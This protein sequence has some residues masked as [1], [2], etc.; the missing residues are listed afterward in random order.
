M[1]KDGQNTPTSIALD[2]NGNIFLTG[3]YAE[4]DQSDTNF[5]PQ[6]PPAGLGCSITPDIHPYIWTGIFVTRFDSNGCYAWTKTPNIGEGLGDSVA[7]DHTGNI[8]IGGVT[9][10]QIDFD[11]DGPGDPQGVAGTSNSFLTKLG[12]DG[13]YQWTETQQSVGFGHIQVDALN[14]VYYA[15]NFSAATDFDPG[16]GPLDVDV[17]SPVG[18]QGFYFTKINADGTYGGTSVV[19]PGIA[20]TDS[21][22]YNDVVRDQFGH[23]YATGYL[24]DPGQ[25]GTYTDF[26][27][28]RHQLFNPAN[29]PPTAD[30]GTD[31]TIIDSDS[32]GSEIVN[33]NGNA[34]I[35][36]DDGIE[37]YLWLDSA[38]PI[39]T[40][41]NISPS[42]SV[43]V[44]SI[45]LIVTDY[46][47]A[48]NSATVTVT[49]DVDTDGDGQGNNADTDDDNDGMPDVFENTYGLDPL[50]AADASGDVDGDGLTNLQEYGLG[51]DPTV[52][53]TDS[54]GMPDGFEVTYGLNPLDPS[55]AA[56][57]PDGDGISNLNEYLQGTDPTTF[58][59][60]PI[61]Y[62]EYGWTDLLTGYGSVD[63]QAVVTDVQGNVYDVG[64][65]STAIDFDPTAGVDSRSPTTAYKRAVYVRKLNADGSYGWT[66]TIGGTDNNFAWSVALDGAGN[67]YVAGYFYGTTDF[68]PGAAQ[69]NHV[70][71]GGA[72]F[73][74]T[75]LNA[76][77]TYG[78][79]RT[80]GGASDDRANS[81]SVDSA[82]NVYV[83]GYFQGT[84]DFDP[85]T[86]P[87]TR[88]A[89]GG[90]DAYV[91][92]L[93]ASGAYVWAR[94]FG[95]T[96][97]D[98][99][100]SVTVDSADNVYVAGNFTGNVDLDP[101]S[102][103]YWKTSSG[104]TDIY[105]TTL[106][107]D[108]SYVRSQVIG[109]SGSDT[110]TAVAADDAGYIYVTGWFYSASMDFDPTSGTDYQSK[111]NLYSAFVTKLGSD[112]VSYGWTK[113]LTSSSNILINAVAIGTSGQVHLTGDIGG[114]ADLD[115]GA[116]VVSADGG[117]TGFHHAYLV[118]LDGTDGSYKWSVAPTG[119]AASY[120]YA[121]TVDGVGNVYYAGTAQSTGPLDFNPDGAGDSVA[122]SAWNN[123]FLSKW[124]IIQ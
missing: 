113:V 79:T 52:A 97:S 121:V 86:G 48:T 17:Q 37:S 51:T 68:D 22:T 107:A 118:T 88:I 114:I 10:G 32:S 35:D 34:S 82:G 33:L 19:D 21:V 89:A 100:Q 70:S 5:T 74:V 62:Y 96:G 73:F 12:N 76:D 83:A 38:T 13:A 99:A 123:G 50:S 40:L 120:G 25:P 31:Q 1:A 7:V 69:D 92:K 14:N 80:F 28:G 77:G 98:V 64:H 94:T 72:D 42:L 101:T 117:G 111:A 105:V 59:G 106:G 63:T 8:Y 108:G 93:D 43:G 27:S 3:Y 18:S 112:G 65:F 67:M 29:N 15:G 116:G 85:V 61:G 49:V 122:L 24:Y 81:V 124:N 47:G 109:G 55:D 2:D 4:Y 46:M 104:G 91:M 87:D 75:K 78:W 9:Y 71:N 115:P 56:L 110:A 44:H 36:I 90:Y 30:A 66:Q 60:T 45:N 57:D 20:G 39:G 102:G 84:V 23:L 95:G 54:D 53:D 103:S 6:N 41:D 26:L 16:T 119:N 58:D 11:T